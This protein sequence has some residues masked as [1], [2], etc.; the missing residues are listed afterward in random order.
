[1]LTCDEDR[2]FRATAEMEYLNIKGAVSRDTVHL[3]GPGP[4]P[5]TKL[6]RAVISPREDLCK[7]LLKCRWSVILL[8][9]P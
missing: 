4:W 2:M 6:T 9:T 7:Y 5:E 1:M 8:L 3:L